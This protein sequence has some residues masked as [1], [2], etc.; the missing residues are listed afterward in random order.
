M[1]SSRPY[2]RGKWLR[3]IENYKSIVINVGRIDAVTCAGLT[4]SIDWKEILVQSSSEETAGGE[5]G[6]PA[7]SGK[8][9]QRQNT[10]MKAITDSEGRLVRQHSKSILSLRRPR[11]QLLVVA[12][13]GD[14]VFKVDFSVK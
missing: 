14:S 3:S 4:A 12:I 6:T 7:R 5:E 1:L 10:S 8:V 9:L 2:T 13:N 11:P